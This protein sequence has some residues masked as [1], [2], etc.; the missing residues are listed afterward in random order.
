M[1]MAWT[2]F[3]TPDGPN[4]IEA[5]PSLYTD[6]VITLNARLWR[7]QRIDDGE[8]QWLCDTM[9][10]ELGHLLGHPDEGQSD[11][12]SIQYPVLEPGSPN[13]DS[14]AQCRHV[15]LWYGEERFTGSEQ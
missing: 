2:S 7:G 4:D 15:V 6:C 9:T 12:R 11:P 1:L 8:F 10:H 3:T 5:S 14:V 13:F